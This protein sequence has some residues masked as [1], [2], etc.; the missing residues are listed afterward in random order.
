MKKIFVLLILLSLI[1]PLLAQD[2]FNCFTILSGKYA[3]DDESVFLAHNEDD[4]GKQTV[5]LYKVPR[6][7]ANDSSPLPPACSWW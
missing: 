6:V 7:T 2:N 5:N 1:S 4:G 3:T